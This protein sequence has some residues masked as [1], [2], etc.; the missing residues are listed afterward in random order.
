MDPETHAAMMQALTEMYGLEGSWGDQYVAFWG[1]LVR[2]DFG[3]S[4]FQFPTT[5]KK[6]I[7]QSLPW[8]LGLLMTTMMTSW[9]VGNLV[10]AIGGYFPR[11]RWS[12]ILDAIT[13]IIRP[14]PYYI[15]ALALLLLLAYVVKLFPVS[16]G[17]SL[18]RR[19]TFS[20]SFIKDV[21]WHSALPAISQITLG[22]AVTFQTMKLIVQNVNSENFVQ[23][24]KLGGV[25]G[26]RILSKY[27]IRN[28][29]LPQITGLA[30]N[31]GQIFGGALITE[32]V[33]SYPGIGTL[34]YNAIINGDYNL[35]MG[36][37]I[38]SIIAITTAI[39]VLDLLYPI[40]DPRIRHT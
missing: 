12:R 22:S 10:G 36:I 11:K 1:R 30:L 16:G 4:F 32:M 37:T 34:L 5:V 6:L 13:M 20:W 2:G 24:A 29:I 7:G 14:L 9:T 28:A 35:I 19:P 3:V 38:F 25:T 39:L 23:Y 31:F 33:F 8:T 27:V 21:L 15:F 40:F 26:S 18:G 17:Y